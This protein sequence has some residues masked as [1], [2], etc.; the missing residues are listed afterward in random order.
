MVLPPH[1]L[2]NEQS[3]S[4]RRKRALDTAYCLRN[5]EDNCCVR[6]LFIDF[7]Q[8]LGWKWIHEP[9]G[10]FANFCAGPCPYLRSTD[11]YHSTV[12]PDPLSVPGSLQDIYIFHMYGDRIVNANSRRSC[13]K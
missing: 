7:R 6:S 10:Y 4:G 2:S 9:K 3:D 11:T 8:D 13:F 1:R 12:L 5:Y